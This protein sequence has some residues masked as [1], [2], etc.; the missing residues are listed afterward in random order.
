MRIEQAELWCEKV[1]R[2]KKLRGLIRCI[3]EEGEAGS[4]RAPY[5]TV[6]Q[7]SGFNTVAHRIHPAPEDADRLNAVMLRELRFVEAELAKEFDDGDV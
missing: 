4:V 2:I 7:D 6:I 5:F 1:K 3:T